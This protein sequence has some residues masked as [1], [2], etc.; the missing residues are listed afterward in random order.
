MTKAE[1]ITL[2]QQY[3]ENEETSYVDNIP[4]FIKLAEEDIYRS[5]QLPVERTNETS[6][7][8]VGEPYLGLPTG[9]LSAYEIAVIDEGVYF[10]LINKDVSFIRE[11]YPSAT[12]TGVPRFFAVFDEDTMILGPAPDD[13]YSI[14]MH[15]FRQPASLVDGGD[16][17]TTWLSEY[18]ENAM[19]FGAL[20]QGYIYMKGDQDVIKSYMEAYGKAIENLKLIAE[21]RN[22]KDSYRT[23]DQRIPA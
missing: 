17:D 20:L 19:L 9:F 4:L 23:S 21:G 14:E 1:L 10:Y 3:L 13:D 8:V 22:R 6:T 18:G 2:L 5:V 12:Q 7:L 16:G 15:Y 11:A